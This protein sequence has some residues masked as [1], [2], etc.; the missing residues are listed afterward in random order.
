MTPSKRGILDSLS[1][2]SEYHHKQQ[3]LHRSIP[4]EINNCA[5]VN[6]EQNN[7]AHNLD[8]VLSSASRAEIFAHPSID[9]LRVSSLCVLLNY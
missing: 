5:I 2:A 6:I 4:Q 3:R 8:A 9:L 1:S 7:T